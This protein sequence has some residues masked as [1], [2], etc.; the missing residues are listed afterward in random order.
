MS[1]IFT[2]PIKAREVIKNPSWEQLRGWASIEETTTRYGSP[3]YISRIRSRSARFTD[4]VFD[5]PDAEQH[6]WLEGVQ[7]AL[8]TERLIQLDR[9]M[10]NAPDF[11][12]HCRFYVPVDHA[13]LAFMWGQSLFDAPPEYAD[14]ERADLTTVMVGKWRDKVM[15]RRILVDPV[16]F[17]TYALG[18]DYMGEVKK[19]FLRMAMY[20]AKT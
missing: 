4:I 11:R 14:R 2:R 5:G 7:A 19:S 8:A 1:E 6:R 17:T 12:L 20:W 16:T 9:I 10:G 13:R 3:R 15:E 18:S